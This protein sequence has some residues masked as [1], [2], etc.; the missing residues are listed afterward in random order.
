MK[1]FMTPLASFL[2]FSLCL[3]LIFSAVPPS[4]LHADPIIALEDATLGVLSQ[5]VGTSAKGLQILTNGSA[6][7]V[8][9]VTVLAN[10]NVGIGIGTVAPTE[11]LQVVGNITATGNI[12]GKFRGFRAYRNA[13]QS[14]P[15]DVWTKVNF[16]AEEFDTNNEFDSA[17]TYKFT[18]TSQG[19]YTCS[20]S[21][22][23]DGTNGGIYAAAIRKNGSDHGYT[24]IRNVEVQAEI[25][26]TDV[27]NMNGAQITWRFLH[28]KPGGATSTPWERTNIPIFSAISWA[29]DPVEIQGDLMKKYM[30]PLTSLLR[31][32]L[33]L[34]LIMLS[35][36]LPMLHADPAI[37]LKDATAVTVFSLEMGS[38]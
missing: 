8:T 31:F 13:V 22:H 5:I 32:S 2:R 24:M 12:T 15:S 3:S 25:T 34:S 26:L 29:L 4:L 19:Y 28:I 16:N 33:C 23:L 18:P 30:T 21:V 6:A 1:K 27:M 14:I 36:P 9:A 17:S 38:V 37:A 10:G 35:S 11:K 20:A 7:P